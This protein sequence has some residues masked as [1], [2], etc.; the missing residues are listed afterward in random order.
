[1]TRDKGISENLAF[2]GALGDQEVLVSTKEG[3]SSQRVYA[4]CST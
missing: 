1:M 3:V 2:N 4:M